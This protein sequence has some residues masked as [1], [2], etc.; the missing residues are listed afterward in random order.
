MFRP[1]LVSTLLGCVTLGAVLPASAAPESRPGASAQQA[2]WNKT[3]RRVTIMR[4]KWGIPHVFG[5]SDDDAVFGLLYAQAE[6]DFNRIELNY[7]NA[8]G[9]LAEVEGEAEIWRDLRMKMYITPED[10]KAK[11]AASPAWL[12]KLMVAFADGLNFYLHTHPEVKPRLITHFEPWMALA[13]SEGSIGGDIESI[14]LKD[15]EQFYGKKTAL[16]LADESNALDKE[17]RGSNGVAIAPKLSESGHALLLIN[18]HTSFYFRPEVHVVSDEGLNA[19]GAVT[20]GQFFVYQGFNDKAGWMH[21][22]GG[23]DVIDEYLETVTEKDGKYVYRYGSGERALREVTVTLPYK[24]AGG[25]ASKTVTAYFSHHGPVVRE[26]G[27]KW[28]SVRLMEEPLKALTQ[29]YTRTKARNYKQFRASMELRTNSSNNTVYADGDG[30]IA[31]FHGNFV[32][33]R[34]T[35]FDWKKPVDGSN[36]A[37]EWQGLHAID[38]TITL[39]NPSGGWIQNTNNWPF[40]ASGASSPRQQDYPR[41]MWSL[42]EN[43]RGLHAVAVL[44]NRKDFTL[45]SLIAAAYDSHLTAFDPLIASLSAAYDQ[46][47]EGDALKAQLAPQ[48][49][50]LRGWD[51]RYG[52]ASVPTSLA[53]YWGQDMLEKAS[54]AAKAKGVPTPDYIRDSLAPAER[55]Q[56]LVRATAKLEADFG[57]WQMP[58]GEINRFQR[59]SG[60]VRQQYDDAKPSYPVAFASATWG[61][62]AAFGMAAPQKTKRIYGDRGNSFVAAVEFGPR[63]RAKSILA[64]GN[65]SNPASPHFSDQAEMY[66]KGQFKDV[67]FY[68]ADIEKQ[69]ERKYHPGQ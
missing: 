19:Y 18:P 16:A 33:R 48:M 46:L 45:D 58:W 12:R 38:E 10:M 32:P 17:P 3:A 6:D 31:Y 24:T 40:A 68:K 9:R 23:G 41:Y 52:V 27:G 13:F 66:S 25:M 64:G 21:T 56:A 11:Y 2:R 42:P 61:S 65:S 51:R 22:S 44:E 53:I 20:W 63:V 67:L 30:N 29:S 8:L 60:D 39:F 50:A 47:G 37:T 26:E 55:L 5:K 69:L 35:A 14:N 54:G 36:P 34:D 49:A 4:D 62:L 59:I 57:T 28:V 43:A 15:L 7:I 1:I